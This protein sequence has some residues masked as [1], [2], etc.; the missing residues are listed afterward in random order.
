M[1]GDEKCAIISVKD[2]WA[3]CPIC[4]YN[5]LKRV[6]PDEHAE[7]VYVHCRRCKNDIPMVLKQGQ[8]LQG[9]GRQ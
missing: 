4:H 3:S 9:Q 6:R 2:G 8:C 7:L 1:T 5:R